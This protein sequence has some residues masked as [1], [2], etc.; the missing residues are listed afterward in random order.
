MRLLHLASDFLSGF[1]LSFVLS[2]LPYVCSFGYEVPFYN[3]K[4]NIKSFMAKNN[5]HEYKVHEYKIRPKT[6]GQEM[7]WE[8]LQNNN[9]KVLL[10][11]GPAGTGKTFLACHHAVNMLQN[12]YIDKIILTRP[13]VSADEEMGF[14]PGDLMHKMDPWTKPLF[15]VLKERYT[16][17]EIESFLKK[18]VIEICPLAYM[19]GRT[20][21]NALIIADE[22][23]NSTPNQMFMLVTRLG[24]NSRLV[25]T[26]DL[27][28]T[29][30][31]NKMNGLEDLNSRILHSINI[32][33][34][35]N[36]DDF[37]EKTGIKLNTLTNT[38]IQRSQIV[39]NIIN[40]Y[41][42]TN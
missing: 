38:D 13:L 35:H 14:L 39:S 2:Y 3:S 1:G 5:I 15:D 27:Q 42:R 7:Y 34:N 41:D 36:D 4:L 11:V 6:H 10:S 18:E 33:Y 17:Y 40:L 26:G 37:V 16:T 12:N 20:F 32:F 21:K 25:V 29:D 23:Q 24:F 8:D 31:M 22:M 30:L 28:Q 9:I 19:R